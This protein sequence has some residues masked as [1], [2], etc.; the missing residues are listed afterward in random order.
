MHPVSV[1][2]GV[3]VGSVAR[4]PLTRLWSMAI[5]VR[6]HGG[7][8]ARAVLGG[9]AVAIAPVIVSMA[10]RRYLVK[11][12][13]GAVVTD[14]VLVDAEIAAVLGA[15]VRPDGR[16]STTLARRV[17]AGVALYERGSV[18]SLV[19]SGA[20]GVNG[21]EPGV[22]ARRAVELGVP[23]ERIALDRAG[24]DTAATCR[25]LAVDYPGR[26]IVLVTQAFHANRTAYLAA[27]AGLDA[28]VFAAADA[29]LRPTA[30]YRARA[31]EV[32][33]SIKALFL[34]RF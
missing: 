19:M 21:D 7:P 18:A 30:R 6:R 3:P 15:G 17:D 14:P 2:H 13:T 23:P 8:I 27:K 24:V 5:P 16:P 34:D 9:A 12:T 28:V 20:D 31:R 4:S 10:A 33:A 11:R 1:I 32:P 25:R 22:M 29:E 26:T